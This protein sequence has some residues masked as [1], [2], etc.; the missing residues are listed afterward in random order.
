MSYSL[1]SGSFLIPYI[2]LKWQPLLYL[3]W[4]KGSTQFVFVRVTQLLLNELRL[5]GWDLRETF[6]RT[7]SWLSLV[8][9]THT[10]VIGEEELQLRKH[11]HQKSV[12]HSL[13]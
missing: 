13:D 6:A 7:L 9:L 12:V 4:E 8:I 11:L 5:E 2:W 3:T 10:R 1:V